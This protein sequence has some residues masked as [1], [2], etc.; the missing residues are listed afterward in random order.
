MSSSLRQI[1][2]A[3]L[4][5]TGLDNGGLLVVVDLT[6]ARS[7]SLESLDDLQRLLVSDLTEDDVL[8]IEPAGD[9]GGDEELGTVAVDKMSATSSIFGCGGIICML[10][11]TCLVRRW[12]WREVLAWCACGRSSHQRTSRRRWTCHQC[13]I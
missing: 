12:P 4:Q 11:L 5:D 1:Q 3:N 2:N 13:P 9:D 8:A 6:A 7:G 10:L